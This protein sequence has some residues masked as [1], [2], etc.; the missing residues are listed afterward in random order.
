MLHDFSQLI[1]NFP[2]AFDTLINTVKFWIR[3]R[4]LYDPKKAIIGTIVGKWPNR[5]LKDS[6]ISIYSTPT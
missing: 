1:E 4:A 2:R 6:Q 5:I 3:L